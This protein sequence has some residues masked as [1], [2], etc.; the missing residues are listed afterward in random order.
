MVHFAIKTSFISGFF[1]G[2]LFYTFF[3][4]KNHRM[5]KTEDNIFDGR[6][7]KKYKTCLTMEAE[8]KNE[9]RERK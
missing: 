7:A 5:A 1:V 9:E 3:V 8:K 6:N 2:L 4:Y